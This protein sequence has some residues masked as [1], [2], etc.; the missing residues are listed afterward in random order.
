MEA[1]RAKAAAFCFVLPKH[2]LDDEV[3]L[4]DALKFLWAA[5]VLLLQHNAYLRLRAHTARA[6]SFPATPQDEY[7]DEIGWG[8]LLLRQVRALFFQTPNATSSHM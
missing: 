6:R 4:P 7:M 1:K 3:C 2:A 8:P 5:C